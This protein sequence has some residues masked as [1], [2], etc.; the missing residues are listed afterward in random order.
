MYCREAPTALL[1]APTA[2]SVLFLV[3]TPGV[4]VFFFSART[5]G[6]AGTVRRWFRAR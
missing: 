3:F 1:F 5:L 2:Q 4:S 6:A